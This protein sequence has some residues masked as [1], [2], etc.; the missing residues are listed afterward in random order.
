[1]SPTPRK[2]LGNGGKKLGKGNRTLVTV[3][4]KERNS[5]TLDK[6]KGRLLLNTK[7][8]KQPPT[9]AY[10]QKVNK[11]IDIIGGKMS[12]PYSFKYSHTDHQV[13]NSYHGYFFTNPKA[14]FKN[15]TMHV[16][17]ETKGKYKVYMPVDFPLNDMKDLKP[18]GNKRDPEYVKDR[19]D[20]GI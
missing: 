15:V 17:C 3:K 16:C 7:L 14:S 13:I 19:K 12:R 9:A 11:V 5:L 2:D 18:I 20:E 10:K 1:M 6:G 8:R 4:N